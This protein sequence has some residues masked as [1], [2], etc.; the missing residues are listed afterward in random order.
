MMLPRRSLAGGVHLRLQFLQENRL[1]EI[2]ALRVADLG[3]GLQIGQFLE[4][5]DAFGDHGHAE[6]FAERLDGAQ[7][8]L[9][10]RALVDVRNEGAVD[11]DLVGGD[12]GQ[13]RQRRIADAEIVDGD[14]DADARGT[15][16]G[17][18][19]GNASWRRM[20]LRSLRS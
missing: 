14:A 11:L 1:G 15:S 16:A 2:I 19:P 8:A 4:G 10:A 20:R 17:C 18:R 3:R 9:A 12:I 5:L 6:R 13:R 7:D